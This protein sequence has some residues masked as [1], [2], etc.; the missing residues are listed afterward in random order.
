MSYGC[1]CNRPDWSRCVNHIAGGE[2][3]WKQAIDGK[4]S[5]QIV[6]V[7]LAELEDASDRTDSRADYI[8][9]LASHLF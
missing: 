7:L 3:H 2:E 9:A 6:D 4:T 1:Y 8:E 5:D